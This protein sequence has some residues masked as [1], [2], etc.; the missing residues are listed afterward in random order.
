[1]KL[2]FD[3]GGTNMRFAVSKDGEELGVHEKIPTPQKYE[4]ALKAIRELVTS[5]RKD[6]SIDVAAGGV[7]GTF[8][9]TRTMLT[10]SPHLTN[11]VGRALKED[12]S[13]IIGSPVFFENDAAMVGLGEAV[14]GAGKGYSIASYITVSTGVGGA[15]IIDGV[16]DRSVSGF[17]PGHQVIDADGNLCPECAKPGDLENYISGTALRERYGKSPKEITDP[18]VWEQLSD[19][20]A[21]GLLNTSVHW[22]PE[23]IVLGGSMITGDPAISVERTEKKFREIMRGF[24]QV[25]VIKKAQLK[26]DGG[27]LGSLAYLRRKQ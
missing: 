5:L 9:A 13:S 24:E 2:V 21:Y 6:K 11:W 8:D 23:V 22:S 26:D 18:A 3:I 10:R 19:W 27:L 15:R 1:M 7:A 25:P 20:L 14:V 17:E 12:F 4:D 16:I